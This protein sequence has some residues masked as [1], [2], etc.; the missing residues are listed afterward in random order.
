MHVLV[1]G[2]DGL[3]GSNLVRL[4]LERK[5][6]VSV[7]LHPSSRSNT[8]SNLSIQKFTGD[9]LIPDSMEDAFA[10]NVDAVIHAAASTSIWPARSTKVCEVNIQGT[11]NVIDFVLKNKISRFIYIGSG[12]SVNANVEPGS[13]YT[14]PGEKFKLD[15][16][17]SKYHALNYVLDSAKSKNL[18]AIAILPTYMI[19]PFDSLPSSGKMIVAIAKGKLKIYTGG[20]RNFVHVRDVATAI[21]NALEIGT[22]GKYYIAGNENLSYK[23]FFGKVAGIV[24]RPAPKIKIPDWIV[25]SIGYAG[26]TIGSVTKK[27]PLITYPMAR[28]SCENQFVD[29]SDAV[30]ELKMPQTPIKEAVSECYQWFQENKYC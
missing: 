1:T 8:L 11:K 9:I 6:K 26:T 7:F 18:P 12:S 19:G 30:N 24:N 27:E 20:G 23:D 15:Y 3:L 14:Y 21:V 28:I 17:D 5:H 29:S 22:I 25:K 13:K 10:N 16:I 2:A 4:L